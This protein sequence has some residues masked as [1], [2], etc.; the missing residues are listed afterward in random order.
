M[1]DYTEKKKKA[2]QVP[3]FN[4]KQVVTVCE[5][6]EKANDSTA[7][8]SAQKKE[9]KKRKKKHRVMET[10]HERTHICTSTHTSKA[11]L[12]APYLFLA[13]MTQYN[14]KKGCFLPSPGT[15]LLLWWQQMQR[16]PTPRSVFCE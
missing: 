2:T 8:A 3:R 12:L 16:K 13:R 9:K 14:K 10:A 11:R 4:P 15:T 7:A 6:H 1:E 5:A